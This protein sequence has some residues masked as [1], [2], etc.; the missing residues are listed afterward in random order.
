MQ[1]NYKQSKGFNWKD[2]LF[3]AIVVIALVVITI[4]LFVFGGKIENNDRTNELAVRD[5][6]KGLIAVEDGSEIKGTTAIRSKDYIP[7][8]GLG[9]DYVEHSGVT[10][11]VVF[12]DASQNFISATEELSVD[13]DPTLTPENAA[14]ARIMIKPTH[15]PEISRSEIKDYAS[16]LIVEWS[17]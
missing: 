15:D 11:W 5:Y 4:T 1:G 3:K 9:V 13:Y 8:R 6:E 17:K 7:I 10:Y 12:Y 2:S 14:L 16:A